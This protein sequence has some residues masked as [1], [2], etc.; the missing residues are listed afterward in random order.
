M[1]WQE[2]AENYIVRSCV[3]CRTIK[4]RRVSWVGH[5]GRGREIRN[6]YRVLVAKSE[7][8]RSLEG[9]RRRSEDNIK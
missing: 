7:G 4:A 9:P 5:A 2:A 3:I 1:K 8:R 6:A